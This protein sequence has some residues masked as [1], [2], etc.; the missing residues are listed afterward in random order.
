[1]PDVLIAVVLGVV[2]GLTEFLPVS[3]HAHLV[4]GQRL[5]GADPVRF[6][7][8]FDVAVHLGTLAAVLIYHQLVEEML[9]LLVRDSHFVTQVALR[10]SRIEFASQPRQMFGQ[11]QQEIR[12]AVDFSQKAKLLKLADAINRIRVEVVHKLTRRGSLS[13]LT[14]DARRAK[15]TYDRIFAIFDDAHDDFRVV[16]SAYKRDLE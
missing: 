9:R 8:P 6:G 3:S 2:Q 7:L 12:E 15:S 1:M 13:G 11:L 14:R 10:P 16:L 5:L 4:L